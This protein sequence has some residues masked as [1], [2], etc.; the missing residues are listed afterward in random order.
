MNSGAVLQTTI[1]RALASVKKCTC[2]RRVL[3]LCGGEGESCNNF[4]SPQLIN[5][6]VKLPRERYNVHNLQSVKIIM[7]TLR[8]QP[9]LVILRMNIKN[10]SDYYFISL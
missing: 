4:L 5:M 6:A 8:S 1:A 9:Q 3:L 2:T 7:D 10:P